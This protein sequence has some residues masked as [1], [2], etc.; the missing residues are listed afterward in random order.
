MPVAPNKRPRSSLDDAG[1]SSAIV[2][3]VYSFTRTVAYHSRGGL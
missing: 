2:S 1:T 3:R